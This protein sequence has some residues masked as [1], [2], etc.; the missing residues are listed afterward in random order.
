MAGDLNPP[1]APAP[2]LGPEPRIPI[3]AIPV[4]IEESGS[5]Y[6]Q[7]NL[8]L[9]G[10]GDGI[11]I[12]TDNV[13]IDLNGFS[14]T[15]D[16]SATQG[17]GIFHGTTFNIR[18]ITIRNGA[19]SDWPG[20]GIALWDSWDILLEDLHVS[21]CG[22]SGI[23]TSGGATLRGCTASQ[24]SGDGVY[25]GQNSTL[26]DCVAMENAGMGIHASGMSQ[27]TRCSAEANGDDGI[28]I[29]S[30][31]VITN[32]SVRSSDDDGI[33]AG[34]SSVV[35]HCTVSTSGLDPNN[36]GEG[37][38]IRAFIGCLVSQCVVDGNRGHGI[39]ALGTCVVRDCIVRFGYQDGI[40]FE[41]RCRIM[42]NHVEEHT[43]GAAIITSGSGSRIEG[44]SISNGDQGIEVLGAGNLI[45]GNSANDITNTE[46]NAIAGN[47]VGPVVSRFT[48]DTATNPHFNCVH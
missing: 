19:I 31:S 37:H 45:V 44:N 23:H 25:V 16:P 10:D 29:G 11:V 6:L 8:A 48:I 20:S 17:S 46:F 39:F 21:R 3:T 15:G 13:T 33:S 1:G 30:R 12:D 24:S 34:S 4:T 7:R 9:S 2:T 47:T 42:D 14:L 35:S 36:P 22:D 38:G 43:Q 40:V 27:I 5:Y 18:G 26:A 28:H 41:D 32:C